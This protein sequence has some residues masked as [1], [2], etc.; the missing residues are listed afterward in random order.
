ME[1]LVNNLSELIPVSRQ[2]ASKLK[3]GLTV[4]LIGELGA[5]KTTLVSHLM[6]ALG[7]SEPVSSPT[8][9]LQHVYKAPSFIVEHWDLYRLGSLPLELLEPADSKVVRLVEWADKFFELKLDMEI[10]MNFGKTA[11][12]RLIALKTLK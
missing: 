8:F 10:R 3:T 4:G 1:Y 11:D 9:V 7:A 2:I 5:G 12:Q 6:E